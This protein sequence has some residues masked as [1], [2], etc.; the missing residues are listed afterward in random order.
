M[1]MNEK[2]TTRQYANIHLK[3]YK[4]KLNA[5]NELRDKT[6]NEYELGVVQ[7]A[8][9][10]CMDWINHYVEMLNDLEV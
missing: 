3:I 2:I 5:L 6:K 10:G 8:I 4:V 1:D 7:S 9:D